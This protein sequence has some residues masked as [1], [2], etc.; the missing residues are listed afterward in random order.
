MEYMN[1]F[2]D[3]ILNRKSVRKF[4]D[5]PVEKEKIELLLRCAMAAPSAENNQPWLFVVVNDRSL[6]DKLGQELPYSKMLLFAQVA[7]IICGDLKKA[8]NDWE[9]DFW[10]QDCSVASENLLLAAESLGLGAVWTAVFPSQGRV[11]I[12]R[13]ILDLPENIMPLNV[14]PIGY[15]AHKDLPLNKWHEENIHYNK[16]AW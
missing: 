8:L 5:Q 4:L 16:W 9:Q 14:I 12:V 2:I 1:S 10:I 11:K 13:D 7:I 3:T 6:L 15:P